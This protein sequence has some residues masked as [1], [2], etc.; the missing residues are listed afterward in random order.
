MGGT[1]PNHLAMFFYGIFVLNTYLGDLDC[2]EIRAK[3]FPDMKPFKIRSYIEIKVMLGAH[4]A[5][6]VIYF[7]SKMLSKKNDYV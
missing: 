7:V 4:I 1:L 5:C 6:I 3:V 2:N